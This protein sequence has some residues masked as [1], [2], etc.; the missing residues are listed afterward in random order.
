MR[1]S[2]ISGCGWA[3]A[4]STRWCYILADRPHPPDPP[5]AVEAPIKR[6]GPAGARARRNRVAASGRTSG[7]EPDREP[8]VLEQADGRWVSWAPRF[9]FRRAGAARF[10]RSVVWSVG[11][12]RVG[13][14]AGRR[15]ATSRAAP[16]PGRPD[17]VTDTGPPPGGGGSGH[18]GW[19]SRGSTAA[20]VRRGAFRSTPTGSA[21][22]AGGAVP[23]V[24][25]GGAYRRRMT[26]DL[27]AVAPALKNS[28]VTC[29]GSTR[30]RVDL[31]RHSQGGVVIA[32][33]LT[34][35]DPG[36]PTLPPLGTVITLSSP[37]GERPRNGGRRI[38]ETARAG[39]RSAADRR[40]RARHPR[41]A[42]G[43]TAGRGSPL[44]RRPAAPLPGQ[45]D[46]TTIAGW[47]TPPSRR[48]RHGGAGPGAS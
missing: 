20:L 15:R 47:T 5:G 19:Q 38:Q 28:C 23:S 18:T 22:A 48:T 9:R 7:V 31:I 43:R 45:I 2:F 6:V 17:C 12:G 40:T 46:V 11:G 13:A 44:M 26:G 35:Y 36:D 21:T 25:D 10:N 16:R 8:G 1:G 32:T 4:T 42:G 30:P 41:R 39:P 34:H 33:F 29:S 14:G 3:I 37:L 24:A 27:Q